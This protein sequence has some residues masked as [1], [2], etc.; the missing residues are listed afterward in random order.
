AG[1]GFWRACDANVRIAGSD[2]LQLPDRRGYGSEVAANGLSRIVSHRGSRTVFSD[3]SS[4]LLHADV[5]LSEAAYCFDVT[6]SREACED[7]WRS[8][9]ATGLGRFPLRPCRLHGVALGDSAQAPEADLEF[10][11]I[12]LSASRV[13]T[14]SA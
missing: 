4:A 13:A 12:E 9:C 8:E 2:H 3:E 14:Y 5:A 1:A 7:L 11:A 6:G 10:C